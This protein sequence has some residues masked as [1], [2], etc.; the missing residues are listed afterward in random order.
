MLPF[1]KSTTEDGKTNAPV[2]FR[3]VPPSKLLAAVPAR[4]FCRIAIP[5]VGPVVGGTMLMVVPLP[6]CAVPTLLPLLVPVPVSTIVVP[7]A[8]FTVDPPWGVKRCAHGHHYGNGAPGPQQP[9][10]PLFG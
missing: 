2:I 4:G 10:L 5:A 9:H 8:A 3:S 6:I 7:F 1:E